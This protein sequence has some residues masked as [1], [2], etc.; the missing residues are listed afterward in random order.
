MRLDD[1]MSVVPLIASIET[2]IRRVAKCHCTKSL[3]DSLRW[4]AAYLNTS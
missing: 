1:C 3:R 4:W 2:I